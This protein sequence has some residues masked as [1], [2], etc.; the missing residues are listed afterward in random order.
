MGHLLRVFVSDFAPGPVLPDAH[1]DLPQIGAG[2]K[3]QILKPADSPYSGHGAEQIAGI[4]GVQPD[5]FKPLAQL[6]NLAVAGFG[7]QAVVMALSAAVEVTL[8]LRVTDKINGSHGIVPLLL[9]YHKPS[10]VAWEYGVTCGSAEGGSRPRHR[11]GKIAALG[12]VYHGRMPPVKWETDL[13][14]CPAAMDSS[15]SRTRR[16]A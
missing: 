12:L 6:G 5:G 2:N 15:S 10:G 8:G 16:G 7:N 11:R 3:L 4:H 9:F 13:S 14:P 1:A